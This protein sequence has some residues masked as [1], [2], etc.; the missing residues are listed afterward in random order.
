MLRQAEYRAAWYHVVAGH[1]TAHIE[2]MVALCGGNPKWRWQISSQSAFE[3]FHCLYEA[4]EPHITLVLLRCLAHIC[5]G[6][7]AATHNIAELSESHHSTKLW[8]QAGPKPLK[9]APQGCM[10]H[11]QSSELRPC[12][13]ACSQSSSAARPLKPSWGDSHA[14]G[15]IPHSDRSSMSTCCKSRGDHQVCSTAKT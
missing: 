1:L 14:Q 8:A 6:Q 7:Q 10:S 9:A 13:G 11:S 3:T 15:N 4:V 5:T 2:D 12:A